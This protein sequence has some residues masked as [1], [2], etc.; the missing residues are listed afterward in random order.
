MDRWVL[1]AE[2][3][4][5]LRVVSK[6]SLL[7][8]G[9]VREAHVKVAS[10]RRGAREAL[11]SHASYGSK[12]FVDV[13]KDRPCL[14]GDV[15]RV[16]VRNEVFER[17]RLLSRCLVGLW[18]GGS[19]PK[20]ELETVKIKGVSLW[21]LKGSLK[22][23]QMGQRFLLFEFGSYEEAERVL[24]FGKRDFGGNLLDV[25]CFK[26]LVDICEV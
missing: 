23:V 2:K 6:S 3:L 20:W 4:R 18:G 24:N 10:S 17:F 11:V 8:E 19:N 16:Q 12:S 26:S 14:L 7:K 22:V 1:I 21:E 9:G 13:V 5:S 25:G 15:V